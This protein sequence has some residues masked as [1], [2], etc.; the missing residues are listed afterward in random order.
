MAI[1]NPNENDADLQYNGSYAM[2]HEDSGLNFALSFGILDRE[3]MDDA[4]NY[5]AKVGWLKNIFGIGETGVSLDYTRSLNLPTDRDD[6]YSIG[7]AAVQQ[8]DD[9]GAEVFALYRLHS[10]DRDIEP[11]VQDID[12][13]SLGTRVRF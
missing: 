4:Q 7:A 12:V 2:L 9:F 10:L 8:I 6:G 13:F 1:G 3:G 5:F 11:D